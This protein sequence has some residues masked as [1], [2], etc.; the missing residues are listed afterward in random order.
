MAYE[1]KTEDVYEIETDYGYGWEVETTEPS[2]KRAIQCMDLY[3]EEASGLQGIR[4]K[5]KRIPKNASK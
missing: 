4:I 2:L 1:R 3:K 5:K